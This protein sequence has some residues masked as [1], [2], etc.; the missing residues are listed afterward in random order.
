MLY[1]DCELNCLKLTKVLPECLILPLRIPVS[2]T[3]DNTRLTFTA[4][5]ASFLKAKCLKVPKISRIVSNPLIASGKIEK[6]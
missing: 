5:V 4:E 2:L 3:L 1:D 6:Y